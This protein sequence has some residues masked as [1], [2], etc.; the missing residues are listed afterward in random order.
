ML[1]DILLHILKFSGTTKWKLLLLPTYKQLIPG[2][3]SFLTRTNFFHIPKN[4]VKRTK[5][6]EYLFLPSP[7]PHRRITPS[8]SK[9][10]STSHTTTTPWTIH[11]LH[12]RGTCQTF[13]NLRLINGEH[14]SRPPSFSSHVSNGRGGR[15]RERREKK[16]IFRVALC[17]L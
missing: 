2:L 13:S 16:G 6:S 17:A 8:V 9:Q 3:T 10:H 14:R 1:L 5:Y 4:E 11:A 7:S 15:A 12:G